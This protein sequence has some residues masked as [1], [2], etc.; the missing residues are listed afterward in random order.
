MINELN[1]IIQ[2][3]VHHNELKTSESICMWFLC[4]KGILGAF[5]CMHCISYQS[6]SSHILTTPTENGVTPINMRRRKNQE[7]RSV[8]KYLIDP[9]LCI[10]DFVQTVLKFEVVLVCIPN[11]GR[12]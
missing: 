7:L 1:K 3:E 2:E 5:Y 10:M 12:K 8:L 4:Q 11:N 6:T 9:L